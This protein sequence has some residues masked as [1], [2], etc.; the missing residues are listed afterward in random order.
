MHSQLEMTPLTQ[1][2]LLQ[3]K[4]RESLLTI[5]SGRECHGN[6]RRLS[7]ETLLHLYSTRIEDGFDVC[8]QELDD[9][10][11]DN[12]E[13]F[14][15]LIPVFRDLVRS[16]RD[17]SLDTVVEMACEAGNH[18]FLRYWASHVVKYVT[19]ESDAAD[20]SSAFG[21]LLETA[22]NYSGQLDEDTSDDFDTSDEDCPGQGAYRQ[23][24][25]PEGRHGMNRLATEFRTDVSGADWD[26]F[27]VELDKFLYDALTSALMDL[28]PD[29]MLM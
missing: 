20:V 9:S 3:M 10:L 15:G 7:M 26:R 2:P 16:G 8:G 21:K 23:T 25:Y 29:V 5:V 27:A 19:L 11:P 22:C 18:T 14:D 6:C 12:G 4:R 28:E 1:T 17:T 24:H 13:S